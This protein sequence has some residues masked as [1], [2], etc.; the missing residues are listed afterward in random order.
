VDGLDKTPRNEWPNVLV[1]H[2]AF[3]IMVGIGTLLMG[4]GLLTA[5]AGMEATAADNSHFLQLLVLCSPLGFVVLEAGWTVTEVGHNAGPDHASDSVHIPSI[6]F[7][8]S[9]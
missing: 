7:W 9:S 5:W 2:I 6:W 1:V 8:R 4:V 3:Q